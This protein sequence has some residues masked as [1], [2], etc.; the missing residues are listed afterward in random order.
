[1]AQYL[2]RPSEPGQIR[3]VHVHGGERGDQLRLTLEVSHISRAPSYEALSYT[4][5]D[6][7]NNGIV[8]VNG[9]EVS[10]RSNL[11][12]AL[13]AIREARGSVILWVDALCISQDDLAEKS[14]QVQMIGRIFR[15]AR[16][17]VSYTHLTL[18]TIYS[19]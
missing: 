13:L 7:R 15:G 3:Y 5:G 1:M 8:S 14:R 18:P 12:M 6:A 17:A 16:Q 11:H 2:Y 19:V 10:I 4:W 9:L